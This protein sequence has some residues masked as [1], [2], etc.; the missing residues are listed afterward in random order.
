MQALRKILR[1]PTGGSVELS[2]YYDPKSTYYVD[3]ALLVSKELDALLHGKKNKP[4]RFDDPLMALTV[5]KSV[6]VINRN[7]IFKAQPTLLDGPVLKSRYDL[8]A[9]LFAILEADNADRVSEIN[10]DS[11]K[12]ED[13]GY[14]FLRMLVTLRSLPG[15]DRIDFS[16]L[17]KYFQQSMIGHHVL[18]EW[19]VYDAITMHSID[20]ISL[21]IL[22]VYYAYMHSLI[23]DSKFKGFQGFQNTEI[24]LDRGDVSYM[25]SYVTN[26][27]FQMPMVWDLVQ[28]DQDDL[29]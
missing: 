5:L 14:W 1:T 29:N 22:Q 11:I 7:E 16:V 24:L 12:W 15:Y 6:V 28:V 17:Q 10:L 26:V 4:I 13:L 20:I 21:G 2:L 23:K 27:I 9:L 8:E 19:K 3:A 18:M 25:D